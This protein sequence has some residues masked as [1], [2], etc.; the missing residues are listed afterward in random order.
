[1]CSLLL[2]GALLFQI[3]KWASCGWYYICIPHATARDPTIMILSM[4]AK[5]SSMIVFKS[6]VCNHDLY[7]FTPIIVFVQ[8]VVIHYHCDVCRPIRVYVQLGPTL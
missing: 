1:M 4:T 2:Y 8:D 5:F 7:V 3:Y 6:L